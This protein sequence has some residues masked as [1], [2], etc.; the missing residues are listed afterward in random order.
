MSYASTSRCIAS[1][2]AQNASSSSFD[3][4]TRAKSGVSSAR[5]KLLQCCQLCVYAQTRTRVRNLLLDPV[6]LVYKDGELS[7]IASC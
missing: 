2:S 6:L 1:C 7:H 5:K 4:W 3:S